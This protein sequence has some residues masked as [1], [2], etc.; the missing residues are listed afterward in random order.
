MSLGEHHDSGKDISS[1]NQ[2]RKTKSKTSPTQVAYGIHACQ[3]AIKANFVRSVLYLEDSSNKRVTKLTE[4]ASLLGI[5]VE[6]GT[7]KQLNALSG[8]GVHQGI[9]VRLSKLPNYDLRTLIANP[10]P[11]S[12]AFVLDSVT[13]PQNVGALLR[14]AVATKASAVVLSQ[15][16]GPLL[17]PGVHRAS[18]GL[19]FCAPVT[20]PGNLVGAVKD[21]KAAGFWI[22]AADSSE[23]AQDATKFDWPE[24]TALVLGSE[25]GGIRPL[26]LRESDFHVRLPME[27]QVESLNVAV[28]SGA[29]AYLWKQRWATN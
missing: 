1:R 13:D 3:A 2:R 26:L 28:A 16:K 27:Q 4:E 25:E 20:A 12:L 22:V 29:L 7:L 11:L 21:L 24:K 6:K 15:R 10:P 5:P 18:A 9:L 19:S 8:E 23:G 14:V 17:T